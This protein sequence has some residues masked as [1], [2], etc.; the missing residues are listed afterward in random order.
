MQPI[1]WLFSVQ[2]PGASYRQFY[3]TVSDSHEHAMALVVRHRSLTS[4]KIRL[5]RILTDAE[6][7]LLGLQPGEVKLYAT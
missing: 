1:G 2:A 7:R 6:I 3:A 5:E 4:E